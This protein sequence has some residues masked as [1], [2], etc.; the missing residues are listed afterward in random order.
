MLPRLSGVPV[1]QCCTVAVPNICRCTFVRMKAYSGIHPTISLNEYQIT[2]RFISLCS[3]D[4]IGAS[5]Q[6]GP[7]LS[8]LDTLDQTKL[9][10]DTGQC[11]GVD[12][13]WKINM[14]SNI[15]GLI[16]GLMESLMYPCSPGLKWSG[17]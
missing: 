12:H 16:K 9:W 13:E 7:V 4:L 17:F 2:H 11:C 1:Y 5:P 15:R 8:V 3:W 6:A 10:S 14:V